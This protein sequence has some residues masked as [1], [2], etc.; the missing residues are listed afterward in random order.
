MIKNALKS[1]AVGIAITWLSAIVFYLSLCFTELKW[2]SID[3]ELVR[4]FC[5]I[6]TF[7]NKDEWKEVA[8]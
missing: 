3:W 2:L 8:R 6:K 1:S 7:L 4:G 5:A